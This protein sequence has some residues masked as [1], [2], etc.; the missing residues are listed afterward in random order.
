MDT[1][2]TFAVNM[3]ALEIVVVV[4]ADNDNMD[5]NV[6]VGKVVAIVVAVAFDAYIVED[7]HTHSD[8]GCSIL[9]VA[10]VGADAEDGVIVVVVELMFQ[11]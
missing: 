11:I 4:V 3:V 6:V 7:T 1:V 8:N 10:G 2:D 9:V 5:Y